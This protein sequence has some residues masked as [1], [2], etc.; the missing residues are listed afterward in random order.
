M[1]G[2]LIWFRLIYD[3]SVP[4]VESRR[5][6]EN[7]LSAT[8]IKTPIKKMTILAHTQLN[9]SLEAQKLEVHT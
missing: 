4:F 1:S 2:F 8:S 6:K 9:K 5:G 3:A 7:K